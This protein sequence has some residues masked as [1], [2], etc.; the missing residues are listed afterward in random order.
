MALMVGA[1]T[2][3]GI[4]PGPLVMTK[5]PTLFWGVIASMWIGNLMLLVINLPLVGMWVRLLGVPYRLMYPAI[6]LFSCIGI[7]SVRNMAADVLMTAA[8]AIVGYALLKL[9]FETAPL[10]LGFVLGRLMEEN[11][12]RA[13]AISRGDLA[14][15]VQ[16]PIS[17]AMLAVAVLVLVVAVLPNVRRRREE[18]FAAD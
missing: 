8:L 17:A 14:T 16:R 7:Y 9:E 12:R 3:H 2:I 15:F 18:V 11:L 10:L 1:M 5:N 6:L 4:V 13:L